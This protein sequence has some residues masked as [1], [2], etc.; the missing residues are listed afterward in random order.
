L[1]ADEADKKKAKVKA[2]NKASKANDQAAAARS[3]S[4][5]SKATAVSNK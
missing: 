4:S 5:A 3:D 1:L 2:D